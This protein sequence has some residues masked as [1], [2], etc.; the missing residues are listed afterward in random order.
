[1]NCPCQENVITKEK[2]KEDN[3][4]PVHHELQQDNVLSRRER[5]L[6]D[7]AVG[8]SKRA[9][10]ELGLDKEFS[11]SISTD[12][13]SQRGTHDQNVLENDYL[14]NYSTISKESCCY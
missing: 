14:F 12:S 7:G 4:N 8:M 10:K 2:R 1:M 5:K 11:M 6:E 9:M 13:P 3:A